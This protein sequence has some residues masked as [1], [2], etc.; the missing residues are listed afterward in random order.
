M[1]CSMF[2]IICRW[3]DIL[4]VSFLLGKNWKFVTRIFNSAKMDCDPIVSPRFGIMDCTNGDVQGSICTLKCQQYFD[5]DDT[6]E[7]EIESVCQAD[8]TWSVPSFGCTGWLVWFALCVYW[9]FP[10]FWR[11][12]YILSRSMKQRNSWNLAVEYIQCFR[13]DTSMIILICSM[14]SFATEMLLVHFH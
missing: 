12:L 4:I 9:R 11:R 14:S 1:S 13:L 3:E 8:S 10:K 6:I 2:Y 5:L 7:S